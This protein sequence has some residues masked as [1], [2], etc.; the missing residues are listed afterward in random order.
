MRIV[1]INPRS[2]G[3]DLC[4]ELIDNGIDLIISY[5]GSDK[6][7]L[8]KI[9]TEISSRT[10]EEALEKIKKYNPYC[11]LPGCEEAIGATD[12]I[13][14]E[15]GLPHNEPRLQ[16]ARQN[17]DLMLHALNK[18]QIPIARSFTVS[19]LNELKNI[20]I[21]H[22]MIVK[23]V[24]S[25]ASESVNRVSNFEQLTVSARNI[26]GIKN[27]LG[28]VN[29]KLLVQDFLKGPMYV[30]NT[31][32]I[33]GVHLLTDL[34]YK[35]VTYWGN[36]PIS[37]SMCLCQDLSEGRSLLVSYIFD[38]LD[39]LGICFGAAHSEVILTEQGPRLVEVNSRL[40]GPALPAHVLGFIE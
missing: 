7:S 39:A 34:H 24:N 35:D 25:S 37:S 22:E 18:A 27:R 2:S 10:E 19:S 9:H 40:M 4:Q 11:L 30:I 14:Q 26:L 15:L 33:N 36:T 23:P 20:N 13:S 38:C 8:F 17:K 16:E 6:A 5:I 12:R 28:R 3:L 31:V 1:V 32:T 21:D 29:E